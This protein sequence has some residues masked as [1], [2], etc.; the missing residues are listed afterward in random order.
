VYARFPSLHFPYSAAGDPEWTAYAAWAQNGP[1][2]WR[3]FAMADI[4]YL[5]LGLLFFGLMAA[6][7]N[8]CDR[9]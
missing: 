9:L 8:A 1:S 7:A 6:Y 4:V 2:I 3:R 5:V